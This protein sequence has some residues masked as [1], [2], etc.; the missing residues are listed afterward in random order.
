MYNKDLI[1]CPWSVDVAMGRASA[2]L[3]RK[4]INSVVIVSNKDALV[5]HSRNTG[6]YWSSVKCQIMWK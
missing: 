1:C 6:S 2:E 4:F 5:R 3:H